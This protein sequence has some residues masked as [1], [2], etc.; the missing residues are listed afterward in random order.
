MWSWS[1]STG[2]SGDQT[3]RSQQFDGEEKKVADKLPIDR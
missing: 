1:Y 3:H 2:R